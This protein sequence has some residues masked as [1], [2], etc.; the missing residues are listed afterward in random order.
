M[1][2]TKIN[3]DEKI[4]HLAESNHGHGDFQSVK[5]GIFER[6]INTFDPLKC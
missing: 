4:C 1:D 6:K 2:M 3:K 5:E